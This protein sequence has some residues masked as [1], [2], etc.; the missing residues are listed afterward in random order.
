[1]PGGTATVT[2]WN[3]HGVVSL[4]HV[5]LPAS[6]RVALNAD[7]ILAT[8][9]PYVTSKGKVKPPAREDVLKRATVIRM[10]TST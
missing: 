9:G 1:M 10:G 2:R 6:V 8:L 4:Y 7:S 5:P 3:A